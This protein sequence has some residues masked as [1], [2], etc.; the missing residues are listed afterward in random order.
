[1]TDN[2]TTL[3]ERLTE[4]PEGMRLFQQERAIFELTELVCELMAEQRVSRSVLASRLGKSKG[5]ITQ[6]LDGRTNMTVRTAS[7]VLH[8]L[9]RAIHFQDGPLVKSDKYFATSFSWTQSSEEEMVCDGSPWNPRSKPR[10][11]SADKSLRM[12][13]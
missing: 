7:D 4:T 13:V 6:L 1:M 12:A 8:A 10:M 9:G 5:Y 2:K 3:F 11:P